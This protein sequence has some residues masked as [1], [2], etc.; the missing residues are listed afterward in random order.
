MFSAKTSGGTRVG[1]QSHFVRFFSVSLHRNRLMENRAQISV[2][3]VFVA[4]LISVLIRTLCAGNF[5]LLQ[6]L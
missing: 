3:V 4:Y 2:L 5:K 6:Y 1:S